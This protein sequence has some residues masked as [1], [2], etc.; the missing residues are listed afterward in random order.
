M[1]F[2]LSLLLDDG[3]TGAVAA[4]WRRLADAGLSRSM[5]DLGYPPHVTLAVY[6]ELKAQRAAITLDEVFANGARFEVTLTGVATFGAGSGV[7]YAAL[8]PSPN[9]ARL[10]ATALAAIG[11]GCRAHYQAG[12]WT[13]HCTLATGLSDVDT[14]RARKLLADG[15]PLAGSFAAADLVAFAPI[16]DI[17]R[18]PL[19]PLADIS[20]TP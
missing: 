10:H 15:L 14:E 6:D 13:P 3:L 4:Q 16:V 2:A 7:V 18:W 1:A 9:L 17:K 5:L 8:A 12:Q 11:E 19:R 20:R